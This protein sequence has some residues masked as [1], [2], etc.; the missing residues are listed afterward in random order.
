MSEATTPEIGAPGRPQAGAARDISSLKGLLRAI[1]D[2]SPAPEPNLLGRFRSR[3]KCDEDTFSSRARWGPVLAICALCLLLAG[4]VV[5]LPTPALHGEGLVASLGLLIVGAVF[6]VEFAFN[7]GSI[8]WVMILGLGIC[9]GSAAVATVQPGGSAVL[10]CYVGV[11]VSSR[12][13]PRLNALIV[14]IPTVIIVD[15]LILVSGENSVFVALWSTLGFAFT[16]LITRLARATEET[17]ARERSLIEEEKRSL[18]ARTEAAALEERGRI[19]REMHDVL[20]H[21][22]SALAVELEAARLL[23]RRHQAVPELE[24]ALERAHQHATSGLD[25]ARAAIETLRGDDLPGPER[26]AALADSFAAGWDVECEVEV[27]G[28]PRLLSSEARLAIYRTAQ[29]ALTNVRKHAEPKRVDLRLDYGAEGTRL[30][31]SDHGDRDCPNGNGNGPLAGAGSGYGVSGMRERAEL[32]GGRLEAG[33]TRDGYRVELWLP[34]VSR[35]GASANS[36]ARI[37]AEQG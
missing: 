15:T 37:A 34:E 7:P 14:L 26:L 31:V 6:F 5:R 23:A 30:E 27:S 18:A 36:A 17:S 24:S 9:I 13:L 12:R 3:G 2:P 19:A 35:N 32:L 16:F 28:E 10:G 25:E 4:L 8:R 11:G 20:A 29:E 1:W 33:P 21:S 22:L